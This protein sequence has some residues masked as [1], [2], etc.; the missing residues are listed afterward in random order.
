MFSHGSSP[1]ER[2][3]G[4]DVPRSASRP[5]AR[6]QGLCPDA[7]KVACGMLGQT[8]NLQPATFN[9]RRPQIGCSYA[10]QHLLQPLLWCCCSHWLGA[11]RKKLSA[12]PQR[13]KMTISHR[14]GRTPGQAHPRQPRHLQR[15][16][17]RLRPRIRSSRPS[18]PWEA[19]SRPSRPTL[20]TIWAGRALLQPE[21]R[22]ILCI[23]HKS[24]PGKE[25][26]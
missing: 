3:A 12:P 4:R 26:C 5:V 8:C 22:P 16:S 6:N 25:W 17:N 2:A 14:S 13:C 18:P 9:G 19:R 23:N 15:L 1:V 11:L 24:T 7:P 10:A 21:I 20:N